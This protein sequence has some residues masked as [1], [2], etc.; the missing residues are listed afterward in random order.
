[1]TANDRPTTKLWSYNAVTGYWLHER[2]CYADEAERWL[3][4]FRRAEPDVAFRIVKRRPNDKPRKG[5]RECEID[6]T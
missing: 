5:E 4:I 1:M 3:E 6:F 2:N